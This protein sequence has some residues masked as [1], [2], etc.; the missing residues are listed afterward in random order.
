MVDAPPTAIDLRFGTFS[1]DPSW[2]IDPERLV[3]RRGLDRARAEARRSV[4]ELIRPR[5]KPPGRRVL[6]TAR[7][8][9]GAVG[10]W[11]VGARREGG[12]ES[13]ADLSVRLRS[14][15][16]SLGPTYIKLAQIISA[17][18]GVFPDELVGEMQ[19]CRDRVRAEPFSAVRTVIE[20]DLGQ[21]LRDVF[22]TIDPEPVAAASIA[23]VHRA[24]LRDGTECV[25]K[26]Q[27][28]QVAELVRQDL[29]VL[30][31]LAPMLVGRIPVA[32]LAN[33][34]ALV[35]LFAETIVEE[36]DFRLEAENLLDVARVLRQLDQTQWVVPRPHPELVT[37]RVLVMERVGGFRFE[38]ASGMRTAG[39]DTHA[40]VR[41]VMVAFLESATL[42]GVFHGDFH[43]GNLFVQPDGKVAL[44]D[45]GIT[46]RLDDVK[47]RAFLRLMMGSTTNDL[48]VQMGAL[49]D[50]GALPPDTDLQA[51][52]D[53][54]GLEDAPVDPTTL[55]QEELLREVQRVVKALLGYGA[56]MPK[57]LMLFV[58]NMIFLS[59]MIDRL[60]PDLDLIA[61]VQ[62]IALHFA[63][64]HG[65]Q[66]QRDSGLTVDADDIDLT[67]VKASW[68]LERDVD[69]ITY[70]ELR[71]R[72]E[73]IVKRMGDKS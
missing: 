29:A 68:G 25:V 59:S 64:A 2:T 40:V 63:V 72:R 57:E 6:A 37:R 43:G 71:R 12:H 48:M 1:D 51:V 53:E 36:L 67:G 52:I 14:A 39:V 7:H 42:H 23:Q 22:L 55:S 3:W 35:R 66:L 17:G 26:V 41:N 15:A 54:L 30:G 47:R 65:R 50:L 31:W 5:R 8:L 10:R 61:E 11:Y 62:H 45:Y 20:E 9:G 4:P 70:A 73:L 13:K 46:G 38:D 32:A 49:R 60:A 58:K 69:A 56:R 27:R 24:R 44:L 19:R 28:P 33:P 34:P 16:E 21:P 18:E